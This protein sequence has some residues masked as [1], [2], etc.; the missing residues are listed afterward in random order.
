[1]RTLT[2]LTTRILSFVAVLQMLGLAM[3]LLAQVAAVR[4]GYAPSDWH[5]IGV[6]L[7]AS[8][9]LVSSAGLVRGR[10][11]AI[12]TAIVLQA[13]Q[14]V[15]ISTPAVT[16]QLVMGPVARLVLI[17]QSITA[18]FGAYGSFAFGFDQLSSPPLMFN[19]VPL[20]VGVVLL[21]LRW[22]RGT[23]AALPDGAA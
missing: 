5:W 9:T 19:L 7:V 23:T 12:T 15:G 13:L 10:E 2:P 17:N 3:M 20:V 18:Q 11:R 4:Q 1:L 8:A 22:R 6:A 16:F 14:V 21:R